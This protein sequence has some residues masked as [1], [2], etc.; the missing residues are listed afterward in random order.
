MEK[1]MTKLNMNDLVVETLVKATER[2]YFDRS[3]CIGLEHIVLAEKIVAYRTLLEDYIREV[4]ND[5]DYHGAQ[6]Y[7]NIFNLSQKIID[8]KYKENVKYE[9]ICDF[10][11]D[12]NQ[13]LYQF[14]NTVLQDND[15]G[16]RWIREYKKVKIHMNT[17]DTDNVYFKS[18]MESLIESVFKLLDPPIDESTDDFT[19]KCQ[20]IDLNM[21]PLIMSID[22]INVT[23]QDKF[24]NGKVLNLILFTNFKNG[25]FYFI[26]QNIDLRSKDSTYYLTTINKYKTKCNQI[27]KKFANGF[28]WK[29]E[30]HF[31]K[32]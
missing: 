30:Y 8:D 25:L 2:Y 29:D 22:K 32:E 1:L 28:G 3:K 13:F 21:H 4:S 24:I 26:K 14:Y 31:F 23:T 11:E 19:T 20:I 5:S 12:T 9:Y 17:I 18:I 15:G 7:N 16:S 27:L 10:M 6:I